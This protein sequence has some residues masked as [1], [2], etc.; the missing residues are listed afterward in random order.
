[1][2]R[3][4]ALVLL[5]LGCTP[6]DSS[7]ARAWPATG[8]TKTFDLTVTE[9]DWVVGPGAV[10]KARVYN[11]TIPGPTLEVTAGDTVVVNVKNETSTA[12]SVH[13]HVVEF[14][15]P[16]DGTDP[17][18][19]AQPGQTVTV[20]WKATYA[21]TFP[22]HDHAQET[23]MARGLFGALVVHAP[24]EKPADEHVV[25]LGDLN[26]A[27]FKTLPGVAD[28]VTGE[29]PDAGVYRGEHQYMHTINGHSYEDAV[30]SFSG[31]VGR[32]SRWRI[33]NI[34]N[35]M[36]TWHIHGHRWLNADG[37]LTDNIQLAP[38]RPSS[39]W[40]TA[41]EAGSCT[42]ISPTTWRAG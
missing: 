7:T 4:I 8:Q 12:V 29:F 24:D 16:N 13:T 33:V 38:G 10:Y 35:E 5:L 9:R 18:R 2:R 20:T 27:F 42:A 3:S 1:M 34:G 26:T 14:D 22:Y 39:S 19:F 25:V 6:A 21:G 36:H 32:L 17:A 11:G 31:K 41:P 23:G 28:P 30:E 40:R 15:E 37:V